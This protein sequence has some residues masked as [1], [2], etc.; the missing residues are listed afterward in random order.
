MLS[1]NFA[2]PSIESEASLVCKQGSFVSVDGIIKDRDHLTIDANSGRKAS[3]PASP[4]SVH[5]DNQMNEAVCCTRSDFSSLLSSSVDGCRALT[6]SAMLLFQIVNSL[7]RCTCNVRADRDTE[8]LSACFPSCISRMKPKLDAT[9][10]SSD[11]FACSK[12]LKD[13]GV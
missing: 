6:K 13:L 2:A 7:S 4:N 12:S 3:N 9:S 11:V 10:R 8:P 5:R 1:E